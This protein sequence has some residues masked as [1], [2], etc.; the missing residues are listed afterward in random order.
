M[1]EFKPKVGSKTSVTLFINAI[2]RRKLDLIADTENLTTEQVL[3]KLI[4]NYTPAP[5]EVKAGEFRTIYMSDITRLRKIKPGA[6]IVLIPTT[7]RRKCKSK[8]SLP[9]EVH[10]GF[11]GG[12]ITWGEYKRQ[13]IERWMLPDAQAEIARLRKLRETQDVYITGFERD[14]EH[15]IRRM[16]VDFVNGKLV[17]T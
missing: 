12:K 17:W 3:E 16:F 5:A 15:S 13:F 7:P 6:L 9:Y 1:T 4:V 2:V 14:E 10:V 11:R 8:L